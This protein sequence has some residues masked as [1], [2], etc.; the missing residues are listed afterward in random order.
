MDQPLV[1]HE[2]WRPFQGVSRGPVGRLSFQRVTEP[3][4]PDGSNWLQRHPKGLQRM[5]RRPKASNG[6][7]MGGNGEGGTERDG[8]GKKTL[9]SSMVRCRG[10]QNAPHNSVR[11]GPRGKQLGGN[12]YYYYYFQPSCS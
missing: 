3:I 2:T 8:H 11:Y 9:D 6:F 5:P 1:V 7:Q 10:G 4:S 12:N